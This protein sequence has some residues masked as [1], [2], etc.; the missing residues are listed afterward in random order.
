MRKKKDMEL[1]ATE[2]KKIEQ[3]EDE[4]KE[5]NKQLAYIQSRAKQIEDKVNQFKKFESFLETVK[6]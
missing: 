4:I 5:K 1:T 2:N 3:L 6:D